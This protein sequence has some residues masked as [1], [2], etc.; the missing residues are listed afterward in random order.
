MHLLSFDIVVCKL[1]VDCTKIVVVGKFGHCLFKL[2]VGSG[3][4]LT[5]M[6]IRGYKGFASSFEV[7][8]NST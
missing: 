7:I 8:G 1:K 6:V 2:A 5:T 3:S 4:V